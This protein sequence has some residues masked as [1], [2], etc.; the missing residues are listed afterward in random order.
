MNTELV[1]TEVYRRSHLAKNVEGNSLSDLH[2]I[3][4]EVLLKAELLTVNSQGKYGRMAQ[5]FFF[6]WR[7]E[8]AV[9]LSP[10]RQKPLFRWSSRRI[11]ST[12]I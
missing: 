3:S 8:E 7:K 5:D 6:I 10:T 4:D 9:H 1:T 12:C 2:E 11:F